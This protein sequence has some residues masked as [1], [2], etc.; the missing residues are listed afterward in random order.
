MFAAQITLC[1]LIDTLAQQWKS[2]RVA[3]RHRSSLANCCSLPLC[4]ARSF[5][6]AGSTVSTGSLGAF[7]VLFILL[8]CSGL[9][10]V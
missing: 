5:F 9:R 4:S 6:T 10:R 8:K 3:Y 7:R 1:V 2:S